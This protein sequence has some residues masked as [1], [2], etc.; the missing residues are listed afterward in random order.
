[1]GNPKPICRSCGYADLKPIFSLG[2]TPLADALLTEKQ[3]GLP[4]LS[5]PLDWVFCPSCSL[6]QITEAV[7]PE[8]LFRRNYPYFS[9]VSNT[10]LKHFRESAEELI[11]SK[12]LNSK[13]LVVEA[14]SNDGYMLRNFAKKNIPVLG[15]DPAERPAQVAQKSGIPTL[16]TFFGKNLARQL[17]DNEGK[18]AD[19]FLANNVLA[20]VPNLNSF[21][22]GVKIILK[23]GGIAVLEVHYLSDL[24]DNDEF[25]TIYHQHM[26]YFSLT[27]LDNLFRKHSLFVTKVN[28]I[29]TYGG[30]LRIFVEHHENIDKSVQLLLEEESKKGVNQLDYYISFANRVLGIKQSLVDKLWA[31]KRQ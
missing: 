31:L 22:E 28:R 13:S 20:H 27:S 8:I 16:C 23:D 24:V 11:K 19:V 29:P 9:S 14:A 10:L 2:Q 25:D 30:S 17:K 7:S 3:L 26:S 15:I 1:M 21:V 5:V 12:R 18:E 4:E 6:V